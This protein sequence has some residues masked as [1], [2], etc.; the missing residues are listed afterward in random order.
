MAPFV[1][2]AL[3][4]DVGALAAVVLPDVCPIVEIM[5]AAD[6]WGVL[7]RRKICI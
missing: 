1:E 4:I 7:F 3:L 2:V 5:M 6:A